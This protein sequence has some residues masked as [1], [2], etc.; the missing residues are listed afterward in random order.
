MKYHTH[1]TAQKECKKNGKTE[2]GSTTSGL[3]R[4]V[5]IS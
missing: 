1:D 4:H 3:P 2:K 5:K